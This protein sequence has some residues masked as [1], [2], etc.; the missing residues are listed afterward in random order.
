MKRMTAKEFVVLHQLD[1]FRFGLLI[2]RGHISG[3]GF[4]LF[5]S[6]GAFDGNN[7]ARHIC[8]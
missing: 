5:P 6:F 4:A 2:P 7:F 3:R 1:L 8:P